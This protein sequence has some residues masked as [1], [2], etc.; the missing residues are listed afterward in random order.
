[1]AKNVKISTKEIVDEVKKGLKR[2]NPL[3]EKYLQDHAIFYLD[4][5]ENNEF[6]GDGWGEN[7]IL[8][9]EIVREVKKQFSFYIDVSYAQE[10]VVEASIQIDNPFLNAATLELFIDDKSIGKEIIRHS[11]FHTYTFALPKTSKNKK[12]K[13][14][15]NVEYSKNGS[16]LFIRHIAGHNVEMSVDQIEQNLHMELN[17]YRMSFEHMIKVLEWHKH[18][19]MLMP[20]DAKL[21]I[22]KKIILKLI[23][24]FTTAQVAYNNYVVDTL[25]TLNN[26]LNKVEEITLL[27]LQM[28]KK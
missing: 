5:V 21:K 3:Y 27:L 9:H 10:M 20:A 15:G 4:P 16:K 12:V 6:L 25:S 28:R 7:I 14:T 24:P 1:M 19:E 13:V 8:N 17:Q 26:R 23:R 18:P 22:F 11:H 2:K